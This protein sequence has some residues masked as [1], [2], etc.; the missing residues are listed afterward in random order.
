MEI[1]LKYHVNGRVKPRE[2]EQIDW[3]P[4]TLGERQ[5]HPLKDTVLDT[6]DRL[7]TG[8]RH[9][10]RIRRDDHA[11]FVTLKGPQH[12]SGSGRFQREELEVQLDETAVDD[13]VQWPA[14]LQVRLGALIGERLLERIVEVRN[15]RITW[16]VVHGDRLVAEIALD[17]GEIRAGDAA[18]TLHEIELER[19]GQGREQELEEL[20]RRLQQVLPLSP[21]PLSK[22]ERGLRL[23][24]GAEPVAMRPDAPLAEA[25]RVVLRK[26]YEKMREAQPGVRDGDHEAVHD[27]R[28]A[29]R[30]LRAMLEVLGAAVYDPDEV[31][32]LR[33]GLRRLARALGAVRDVEVWIESV[34]DFAKQLEPDAQPGVVALLQELGRRREEGRR[35][36]MT[37]LE[38]RRTA[39]LL[40]RLERFVCHVGA[41]VRADAVAPGGRPLRVRDV[42]GSALWARL[43]EVQAFAPIMP[44][45]SIVLLHE[46]RIACK[47]LRYTLELFGDALTDQAKALR[48]DLVRAQDHLGALHDADVALP[49]VVTLLDQD[50][51]NLGL[52]RYRA[53]LATE[54]DCLWLGTSD[55]WATLGSDFRSR[56]AA[57]IASM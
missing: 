27:M 53:H 42:A 15:R 48:D 19:K 2:I 16:D 31:A 14:D 55:V 28:V 33:R 26:H 56:L 37:E 49:M 41:G 24:A 51:A 44:E 9:A 35:D 4:Y 54:R 11:I 45:A 43:E 52:Q 6:P 46:L 7:I 23:A 47:H 20:A 38:H 22:L 18:Q 32:R 34:M 10:L 3:A 25:G 36:L 50:P 17:K 30:R 21:E 57:A 12:S 40:A 13:R 29:T 39:K 8:S 5:V 1:E